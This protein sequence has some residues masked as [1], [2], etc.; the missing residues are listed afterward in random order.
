[1]SG[2]LRHDVPM[3][4]RLAARLD[5]LPRAVLPV[6]VGLI[7]LLIRAWVLPEQRADNPLY[8]LAI[9][10]DRTYLDLAAALNSD[11]VARPWFRRPH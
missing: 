9:L 11:A 10:D 8:T 4:R 7:A 1:M 2:A 3:F 5:A 6:A